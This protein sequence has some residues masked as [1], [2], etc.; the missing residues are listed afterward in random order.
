M[1]QAYTHDMLI[2]VIQAKYPTLEHGR[3]FLVGHPIDS[4]TGEQCG[5]PFI[6][7]WKSVAI[8]M[9][10]ADAL[11]LEFRANEC[12]YRSTL[13]RTYRDRMLAATDG[14]VNPPLDAPVTV[15]AKVSAWEV[16]RQEL[17]DL[18]TQSGFP[19]DIQWPAAPA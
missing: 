17:R 6:A 10:D 2:T 1:K 4:D 7:V 8:A 5:A 13:I 12:A 3:D 11:K 16:Y 9:P 18:T 19:F 15:R 14:M